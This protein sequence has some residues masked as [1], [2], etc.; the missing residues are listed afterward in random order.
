MSY[1]GLFA[2][3]LTEDFHNHYRD[4]GPPRVRWLG[5][6]ALKCPLDLW[7]Y[8][9]LI[10]E[11][12]PSLIIEGG[13][14]AGGSAL[15]MATILDC[16]GTGHLITMDF[17][18]DPHR[19]KHPRIEQVVGNTLDAKTVSHVR[20]RAKAFSGPRMLILDDGHSHEH[21]AEELHLYHDLLK[22][23]DILIV[24]DTNLGGPLWG[25]ESFM[26]RHPERE[27]QRM[28]YAERLLLTFNPKGYYRCAK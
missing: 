10:V 9:E 21:V 16:L 2:D 15:F 22:Q 18:E 3:Q 24:E 28:T 14:C 8:Q 1:Q 26:A 11:L 17:D 13:T 6:E 23:G 20:E 5:V 27:W 7:I 4:P 25:F 12:R 19:P